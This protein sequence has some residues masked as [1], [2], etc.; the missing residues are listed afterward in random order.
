MSLNYQ[1][2]LLLLPLYLLVRILPPKIDSSRHP[3]IKPALVGWS[4]HKREQLL[5]KQLRRG[6]KRNTSVEIYDKT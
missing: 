3:W 1:D 4:K 2:L 6:R 5:P